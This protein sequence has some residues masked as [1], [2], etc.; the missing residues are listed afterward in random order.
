MVILL[1][2]EERNE[3][4]SRMAHLR[5]TLWQSSDRFVSRLKLIN[6][7]RIRERRDCVRCHVGALNKR[8]F[9]GLCSF[10]PSKFDY[11]MSNRF[12]FVFVLEWKTNNWCTPLFSFD[13]DQYKDN[14]M[15]DTFNLGISLSSMLISVDIFERISL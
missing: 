8:S 3:H 4:S 9:D 1:L 10:L 6:I 7:V 13:V 5:S 12:A 11:D 14:S 15:K 2:I